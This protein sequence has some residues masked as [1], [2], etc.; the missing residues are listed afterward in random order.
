MKPTILLYD[1]GIGGLTIYDEVRKALPN[2]HYLYCFDNALFPYSEKSEQELI[3]Q[4]VKIVQ[5]IAEKQPLVLLAKGSR[6]QKMETLIADL[7]RAFH[8]Q[9]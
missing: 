6:S 8:I 1:S 9:F 5:K 7:C 4:A 2:A 3:T